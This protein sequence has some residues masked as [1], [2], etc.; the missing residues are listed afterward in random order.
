MAGLKTH[1]RASYLKRLNKLDGCKAK[2]APNA[3][4]TITRKPMERVKCEAD[5]S[6]LNMPVR[7]SQ[8]SKQE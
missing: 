8:R 6:S 2:Q 7:E 1:S 5:V 4:H 3:R